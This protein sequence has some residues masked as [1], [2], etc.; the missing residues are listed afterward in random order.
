MGTKEKLLTL[1]ESRKGIYLSGEELAASLSVSRAAVWKAV[2]ALRKEGYAIEA[3][4]NRGYCLN[5]DTDI[6]SLPGIREELSVRGLDITLL[7][8]ARS[9][10]DLLRRRAEEGAPEGTVVMALTQSAGK[11]RSGREFFS[12]PDTGL[13]FSILLRPQQDGI[14]TMA[15]AAMCETLAYL[16]AE[17]PGIK[18]VNDLFVKG[19]KVCGILTEGAFSMETGRLEYAVLGVGLNLY[20]PR[21]GFPGELAAVAG[22]AFKE[23]QP[24]LKNR[25][26]AEFLNRF[27]RYY[28]GQGDYVSV[29][30]SHSLATG[31]RVE[32]L[33]GEE[34]RKALVLGI[35]DS[36]RLRVRYDDG[37]EASLSY[38]EIRIRL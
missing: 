13:Y 32:V 18:W 3:G 12:P 2:N 6:L 1:L 4:T 29:Y 23:R 25:L 17:D 7:P 27:F 35:D 28:R 8:T 20:A 31:R 38:G 36:C 16:G 19:K 9:T 37:E 33:R 15:A 34:S 14:T 30:R 26:T 5:S 24:G 21:E 11:G 10:N 22:P